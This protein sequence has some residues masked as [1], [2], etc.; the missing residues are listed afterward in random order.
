[1]KLFKTDRGPVVEVEGRQV[2]L[3]G[4]RWDEL[5]ARDDLCHW[6]AGLITDAAPMSD[7]IDLDGTL[8]A[9]VGSQEVWAAGVTYYRS[10]NARMEEAEQ[11]GGGSFYD[12][13]YDADRPELFF[14]STA[15]RAAGHRQGVRIRQDSQWNVPEPELTLMVSAGG[16][17]V[18]YTIGNDVSSRDIE[19]ENPLY[20]P[21]AKVYDQSCA[22]GP[23][24]LISDQPLPDTTL[25]QLEILRQGEVTFFGSTHLSEMKRAPQLLVQYL[26]LDNSFPSGC[27]LMTGT[28]VVPP[29]NFSLAPGDEIRITIEPIGTLINTVMPLT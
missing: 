11:A 12:R 3:S 19:G 1:M 14:K 2:L 27:F 13:V 26:F 25:I 24:I 4:V 29:N 20:L 15:H 21:Q 7:P 23:G 18:G 22:L 5:F 6:L 9:P 16:K 28:G 10:R 17:I 8:A